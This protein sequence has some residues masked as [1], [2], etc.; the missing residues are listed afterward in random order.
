MTESSYIDFDNLA[1]FDK[2]VQIG[3]FHFGGSTN[4]LIFRLDVKFTPEPDAIPVDP[5]HYQF[6]KHPVL[7]CSKLGTLTSKELRLGDE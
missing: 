7:V 5:S 4:C 2:G 1:H 6:N 3:R